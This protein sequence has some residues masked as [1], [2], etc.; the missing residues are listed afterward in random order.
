MCFLVANKAHPVHVVGAT[1]IP[2][3]PSNMELCPKALYIVY[4]YLQGSA[5]V[6]GRG[7]VCFLDLT[8]YSCE[9]WGKAVITL[10]VVLSNE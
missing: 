10:K 2:S 6:K 5:V 7:T 3:H 4:I 8:A 9:C 1:A